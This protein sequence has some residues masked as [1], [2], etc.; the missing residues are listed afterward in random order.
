MRT[1]KEI[2]VRMPRDSSVD[3]P[4][5]ASR[6]TASDR[7]ISAIARLEHTILE[8]HSIA[9]R[10]A[11]RITRIAGSGPMILAHLIVLAGWIAINMGAV[12]GVRRFDAFPFDLLTA[13]VS[14]EVI[15]LTLFVLLNQNRMTVEADRR[16]HLNMQIDLLVEREMTL[17]L[18]I[19]NELSVREGLP[20]QVTVDVHDEDAAGED[21][22]DRSMIHVS[23]S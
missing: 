2:P 14:V 11:A 18:R 13:L 8:T 9:D 4:S 20:A 6:E 23:L 22:H 19:L 1:W 3:H 15:F 21:T 12:P 10:L 7:N 5:I 17:I 16:T